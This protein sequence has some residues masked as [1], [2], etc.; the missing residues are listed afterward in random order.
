MNDVRKNPFVQNGR[1]G[2]HFNNL[3]SS[4]NAGDG[5]PHCQPCG[6]IG[7]Q[8]I[9]FQ[10]EQCGKSYINKPALKRHIK[11]HST[12]NVVTC[13]ICGKSFYNTKAL[14][15][16]VKIHTGEKPN[17]CSQCSKTFIE[18]GNLEKHM[19]IHTGERP[20]PCNNCE[21]TFRH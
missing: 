6:E 14:K 7:K 9:S 1:C 8:D 3:P 18:S 15:N 16:H 17:S 19:R 11:T 10:C 20:S 21:K 13:D 5:K 2:K 4:A 12:E